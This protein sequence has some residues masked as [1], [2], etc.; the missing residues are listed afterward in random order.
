MKRGQSMSPSL[1]QLSALPDHFTGT[2]R[3][4]VLNRNGSAN[5]LE[6]LSRNYNPMALFNEMKSV[7]NPFSGTLSRVTHISANL[8]A[9]K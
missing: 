9:A 1:A 5:Q 6:T 3:Y 8:K 2:H 7:L 4:I